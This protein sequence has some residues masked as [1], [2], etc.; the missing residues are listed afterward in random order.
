MNTTLA[1]MCATGIGVA[2][3]S[4]L[5]LIAPAAQATTADDCATD[6]QMASGQGNCTM[7]VFAESYS[8]D[9]T[10]GHVKTVNGIKFRGVTKT[11]VL[12]FVSSHGAPHTV[13][14]HA[15]RY[16]LKHRMKLW[17]SYI[18]LEG[19]EVWHWKWYEAGH[20]FY[21]EDDGWYHDGPCNN[22]V[23]VPI[24]HKHI[25]GNAKLYGH[26]KVVK[27][28]KFSGHAKAVLEQ[29]SVSKATAWAN[30]YLYD[31]NGNLV[32]DGNG[33]PTRTCHAEG[34]GKG[35]AYFKAVGR[36]SIKGKIFMSVEAAVSAMTQGANSHLNAQLGGQTHAEVKGRM[37]ASARGKA[38][39]DASA[40][41][42]C[43]N[44][45]LPPP[46]QPPSVKSITITAMTDLNLIAAGKDSGEYDLKVNAS[47]AGGSLTIDP[48][49]GGV[50]KC[51]ST[52]PQGSL[53][54]SNLSAGDSSF[55]VIIYA[56][57]DA[58]KPGSMT[59]TA[60]ATLG[61]AKDVKTDDVVIQY[62]VRA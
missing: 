16:V 59:V 42:I 27:V 48:G 43:T 57:N 49:I 18:N 58:D 45:F 41:A 6:A 12:A 20:V 23:K 56:P 22:K 33:N 46:N 62:P 3:A 9:A 10:H 55:C 17:T 29:N 7:D 24:T 51:D 28:F 25:P 1:R 14:T 21:L 15:R 31:S 32:V 30:G 11:H 47:D 8:H 60:T 39:T 34:H 4:A 19:Q 38:V 26:Y 13:V 36:A 35:Q 52:T 44:T 53:T 61:S 37:W 5:T 54:F 40:G 50:S 2:T